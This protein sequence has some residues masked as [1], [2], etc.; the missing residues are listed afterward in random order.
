MNQ[1]QAL[2]HL[3]TIDLAISEHQSRLAEIEKRLGQNDKVITAET[4]LQHA[5][6]VLTPWQRQARDLELEIKSVSEQAE[7]LEQSMFTSTRS[8]PKELQDMQ[9][10]VASLKRRRA[11][12]EDDLLEAMIE[13]EQGQAARKEAA[14]ALEQARKEWAEEQAALSTEKETLQ[15]ELTELNARRQE[16]L[17]AVS[18]ESLA[19]YETL[20]KSKRG[21]AVSELE[22]NMCKTCGVSQTSTIVQQV[23]QGHKL[24]FC[25][26]CGRILVRL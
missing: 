14:Q 20:R 15:Q 19:I 2:Y 21:H 11:K 23:R 4:A 24:V 5:E 1:A 16:A 25:A 3:Q 17:K 18:E 10:K 6:D 9:D 26:S 12:L 7:T 22:G 8:S 13:I